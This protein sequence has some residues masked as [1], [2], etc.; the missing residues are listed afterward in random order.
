[1]EIVNRV[2]TPSEF[3]DYVLRLPFDSYSTPSPKYVYLHHTVI[4]TV[5]DWD[6]RRTM[7]AMKHYYERQPWTDAQGNHHVGWDS[8]PH[9]F[10]APDGIW[11]FTALSDEG[12]GVAGIQEELSRHI[13][14]VGNYDYQ[15]PVPPVLEQ[16]IAAVGILLIRYGL[17]ATELLF[18][19]DDPNATKTCPGAAVRKEWVVDLVG[20]WMDNFFVEYGLN[21][22]QIPVNVNSAL[23]RYLQG[24]GFKVAPISDEVRFLAGARPTVGQIFLDAERLRKIYVYYFEDER[25]DWNDRIHMFVR[26]N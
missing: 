8:G 7:L 17:L 4:P 26:A 25:G 18:H 23:F 14:M 2:Y 19:R 1:M 24:R 20:K 9:I 22:H 16:M 13:E 12:V 11:E 3:V 21:T 10:V 5:D 15:L 6:G